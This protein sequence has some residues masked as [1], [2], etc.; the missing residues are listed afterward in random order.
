V[1]GA[2]RTKI[3]DSERIEALQKRLQKAALGPE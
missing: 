2:T 1:D 3:H